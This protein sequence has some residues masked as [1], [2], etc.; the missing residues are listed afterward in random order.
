[1]A[2][3]SCL[4]F[5]KKYALAPYTMFIGSGALWGETILFA[6]CLLEEMQ[7]KHTRYI[8]SADFFHGTLEAVPRAWTRDWRDTALPA[9]A[10]AREV[11]L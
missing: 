2:F 11:P 9:P 6:M 8:S 3:L 10:R 7:W 4:P 5:A 1:M